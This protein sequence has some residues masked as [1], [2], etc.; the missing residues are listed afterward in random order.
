MRT[1]WLTAGVIGLISCLAAQERGGRAG[2]FGRPSVLWTALDADHD[3]TISSEE[4]ANAASALR[5][6]DKN[7]DGILTFDEIRPAMPGGRGPD[8][9]ERREGPDGGS[10]DAVEETVKTLM[11]FDAN[12]DGKLQKSE[13]P[14]RMQ[15]IFERGDTNKDGV[16][17][18][19]EIR[20]MARAQAQSQR[21]VGGRGEGEREGGRG[22][23]GPEGMM[24]MD[25]IF[26]AL[27]TNHDNMISADEIDNAP[28]ALRT[29]DKNHDGKLTEDEVRPNFGPGRGFPPQRPQQR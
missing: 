24:R 25:P 3:G 23:G 11:A 16:L 29:L 17:T 7:H 19:E 12:G 18:V 4:I 20:V 28:S 22:R 2:G 27:D 14:E 21:A 10:G 8:G 26:A 5:S 6:L 13:V 1:V 15:G 9:G